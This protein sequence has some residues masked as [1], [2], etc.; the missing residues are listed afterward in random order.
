MSSENRRKISSIRIA[1]DSVYL[2]LGSRV[3][4]MEKSTFVSWLQENSRDV[5]RRSTC[6][7]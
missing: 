2:T 7:L 6:S 5:K 1:K 3:I 4:R